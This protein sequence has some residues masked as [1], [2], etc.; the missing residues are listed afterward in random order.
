MLG[1]NGIEFEVI[2]HVAHVRILK[3]ENTLRREKVQ[4]ASNET[5][6]IVDV[7]EDVRCEDAGRRSVG[8]MHFRAE[9]LVEKFVNGVDAGSARNLRNVGCGFDAEQA[10]VAALKILQKGTVI[11]CNLDDEFTGAKRKAFFDRIGERRKMGAHRVRG[12]RYVD[13]IAEK[14]F[15]IDNL[16]KL[17]ERTIVAHE[18]V[19]RKSRLNVTELLLSQK[20]G[21]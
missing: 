15:R 11:G 19:E 9:P 16:Q 17:Y 2:D 20:S 6:D 3:N 14:D 8:A 4:H 18:H 10:Q 7:R 12:A 5:I 21:C 13:V 1:V